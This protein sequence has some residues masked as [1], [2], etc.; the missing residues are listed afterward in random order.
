MNKIMAY[1][2]NGDC[3]S[4]VKIKAKGMNVL[5]WSLRRVVGVRWSL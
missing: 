5:A 3:E 4:D 1:R 2:E